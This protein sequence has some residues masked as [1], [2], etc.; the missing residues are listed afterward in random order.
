MQTARNR[1][2]LSA[3]VDELNQRL[4]RLEAA[5]LL[6]KQPESKAKEPSPSPPTS[7]PQASSCEPALNDTNVHCTT[8]IA[9]QSGTTSAHPVISGSV[10]DATVTCPGPELSACNGG[11]PA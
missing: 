8:A 7:P 11:N 10:P 1:R 3:Q 5:Q 2:Q 9:E 4:K 6:P